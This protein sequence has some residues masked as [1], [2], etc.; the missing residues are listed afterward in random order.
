LI[1]FNSNESVSASGWFISYKSILPDWCSGVTFL[2]EPTDTFSDGSG[3]FNYQNGSTCMWSIQPDGAEQLIIN[4]LEFDTEE[5]NDQVKIYDADNNQ[6]LATL[7]GTYEPGNLP[8]PITSP[9]G[10]MMLAFSSN[11]TVSMQGWNAYYTIITGVDEK[12]NDLNPVRIFPNPVNDYL[13]L[14]LNLTKEQDVI[15]KL[16]D[17]NGKLIDSKIL[18]NCSGL[19]SKKFDVSEYDTGIYFMEVEGASGSIF[20]KV[21]KTF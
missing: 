9:S 15:I 6:L 11:N 4:F 12:L 21:V 14:E 19:I 18:V 16:T 10:K 3:T 13:T 1:T 5:E 2:T 20:K 8:D 17:V 7:S